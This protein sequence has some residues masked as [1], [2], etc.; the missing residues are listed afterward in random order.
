[1]K[2]NTILNNLNNLKLE[3]K[4]RLTQLEKEDYKNSVKNQS[5]EDQMNR[6]AEI[7]DERRQLYAFLDKF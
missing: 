1:M 2:A 5:R 7:A 6:K 3:A 4:N